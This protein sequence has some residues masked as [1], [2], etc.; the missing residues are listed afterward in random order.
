MKTAPCLVCQIHISGVSKD[1]PTC[2]SCTLKEAYA[3]AQ[4]PENITQFA[5][6][7][8]QDGHR[9]PNIREERP[10]SEYG[11]IMAYI[12][13]LVGYK[14]M[15]A[16]RAGRKANGV[17]KKR[18]FVIVKTRRQFPE[19]TAKVICKALKCSPATVTKVLKKAKDAG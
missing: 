9:G 1:N 17:S 5:K 2:N 7:H 12:K 8:M 13:G 3:D 16:I 4:D 10:V 19:I 14:T 18:Y 15:V 11:E 6:Y